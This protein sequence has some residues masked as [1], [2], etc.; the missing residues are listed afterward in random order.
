MVFRAW[1][2]LL[3]FISRYVKVITPGKITT[4]S[5]SHTR[6]GCTEYYRNTSVLRGKEAMTIS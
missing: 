4:R 2:Q 3:L 5:L 6:D 1:F